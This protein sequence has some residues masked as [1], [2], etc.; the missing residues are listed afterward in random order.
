[1]EPI[2]FWAVIK[3]NYGK[4]LQAFNSQL[5][6]ICYLVRLRCH[7]GI[8]YRNSVFIPHVQGIIRM[9]MTGYLFPKCW[10]TRAYLKLWFIEGLVLSGFSYCEHLNRAA[11]SLFKPAETKQ[12]TIEGFKL[13]HFDL[14]LHLHPFTL[15]LASNEWISIWWLI[16]YNFIC[17]ILLF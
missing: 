14:G 11:Y 4:F 17:L 16:F 7:Y 8:P 5:P 12:K 6:Y 1:M 2:N 9:R 3:R 15:P 13:A 10:A